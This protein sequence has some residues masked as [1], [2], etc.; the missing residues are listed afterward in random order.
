[1]P[2]I[3]KGLDLIKRAGFKAREKDISFT[4]SGTVASE[5]EQLVLTPDNMKVPTKFVLLPGA[6]KSG[7]G[8]FAKVKEACAKDSS[9]IVELEGQWQAHVDPNDS[10]SPPALKVMTFIG[11]KKK[12]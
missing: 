1:M 5:N 2:N 6:D 8:A 7:E 10:K 11:T 3:D 9:A 4:V 12:S